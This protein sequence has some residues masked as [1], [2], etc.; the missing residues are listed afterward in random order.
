MPW[1]AANLAIPPGGQYALG[2]ADQQLQIA[3]QLQERGAQGA[4][5]AG[6]DEPPV[7]E[8]AEEEAM[9]IEPEPPAKR[10]TAEQRA[11]EA[12][13]KAVAKAAA[14]AAAKQVKAAERAAAMLAKEEAARRK[15]AERAAKREAAR[16]SREKERTAAAG[17][18]SRVAKQI[19]QAA[20]RAAAHAVQQAM[21][22]MGVQKAISKPRRAAPHRAKPRRAAPKVHRAVV[23]AP[24]PPPPPPPPSSRGRAI[25]RKGH[26]GDAGEFD[27]AA[28]SY[29]SAPIASKPAVSLADESGVPAFAMPPNRV[30]ARGWHAGTHK[31]FKA[32]VVKLRRAFPRI[33]VTFDADEQGNTHKHALP[34]LDAYLHAA[35]VRA[36]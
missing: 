1:A 25:K 9:I 6:F 3:E 15:A 5:E 30:W 28:S 34:E 4:L 14:K 11:E 2:E 19:E 36:W 12:A 26:Y 24:A 22:A 31:W 13:A 32:R 18:A 8:A 27:G 10:K 7:A 35:D 20:A 16:A 33:H 21:A 17:E 29:R 23:A